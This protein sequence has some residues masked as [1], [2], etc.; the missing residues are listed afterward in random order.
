MPPAHRR[1]PPDSTRLWD[2]ALTAAKVEEVDVHF[3]DLRKKT[4]AAAT[5]TSI[6]AMTRIGNS[7]VRAALIY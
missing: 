6:Q 3:D 5:G 2:K 7:S 4:L 1:C